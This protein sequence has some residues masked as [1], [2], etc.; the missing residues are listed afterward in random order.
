MLSLSIVSEVGSFN[1]VKLRIIPSS[2]VTRVKINSNVHRHSHSKNRIDKKTTSTIISTNI[3]FILL[4]ITISNI[5]GKRPGWIDKRIMNVFFY[6]RLPWIG[7]KERAVLD[8]PSTP[9]LLFTRSTLVL[10]GPHSAG[11]SKRLQKQR[12]FL[13]R[14][15]FCSLPSAALSWGLLKP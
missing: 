6:S 7:W 2:S 13:A 15:Q 1:M 12:T 14:A 8:Q 4:T 10:P 9:F 11:C 3:M 5:M